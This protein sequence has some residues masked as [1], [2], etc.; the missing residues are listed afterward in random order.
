MDVEQS[1]SPAV[2]AA[3]RDL[4]AWWDT[5]AG[6]T[7]SEVHT[8]PGTVDGTAIDFYQL[9]STFY[10][11]VSRGLAHTVCHCMHPWHQLSHVSVWTHGPSLELLHELGMLQIAC[12]CQDHPCATF[13]ICTCSSVMARHHPMSTCCT[14]CVCH[15][16][17]LPAS[18]QHAAAAAGL[19]QGGGVLH[20]AP[21]WHTSS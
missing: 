7:G 11:K 20:A 2:D 21:T 14:L 5:Y 13:A 6:S 10:M 1:V 3:A 9:Y 15:A 19:D 17:P 12:T 16:V 18:R 8:M 4:A